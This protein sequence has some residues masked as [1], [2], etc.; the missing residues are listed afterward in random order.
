MLL[1]LLLQPLLPCLRRATQ[2]HGRSR[3]PRMGRSWES[4][5]CSSAETEVVQAGSI[6]AP[7]QDPC[8][9]E[10]A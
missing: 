10:A 8:P 6:P 2:D 4:M 5:G 7:T 9:S 3:P 1:S